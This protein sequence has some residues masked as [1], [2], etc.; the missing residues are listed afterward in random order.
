VK[1][2]FKITS[3][4]TVNECSDTFLSLAM[5]QSREN[6]VSEL[7]EVN[8]CRPNSLQCSC[9]KHER[10]CEISG[11]HGGDYEEWRLLGYY[12]VWLL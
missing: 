9:F 5:A 12:A 4:I 3:L 7:L 8:Y 6:I 11:F 1:F 2:I 10:R